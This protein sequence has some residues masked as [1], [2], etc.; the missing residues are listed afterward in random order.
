MTPRTAAMSTSASRSWPRG[1]P[2]EPALIFG[3]E[4]LTYG[5]L[6]E[7]ANALAHRLI[8]HGVKPETTVG[9]LIED[10]ASRII[11]LLAVLK[12]GGAYLPLDP[13]LP[14]TRLA[15]MVEDA[16]ASIVLSERHLLAS[17]PQEAE[18]AVSFDALELE[19]GE[20]ERKN[21]AVRLEGA[22]LAYVVFT[23]GS[24]GRAR[25]V[26]VSHQSLLNAADAWEEAYGL[27]NPPLR[28][29]QAAAFSFDVFT[30][31][32]VRAL[33]TGGVLV[34][35]PR[36]VLL[37][38]GALADLIRR[39]RIGFVELVPAVAEASP[40]TWRPRMPTRSQSRSSR[41]A[42]TP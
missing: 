16:R 29:L 4:C 20:A 19:P 23:S 22:N 10:W 1:S 11:G 17:V 27:A 37:D 40:P 32:W 12:A 42:R 36:D 35:C 28:H 25:G 18:K 30:G 21:P 15:A 7:K 24:T 39:E 26:M 14:G 8:A 5:E 31:D 38:P 33:T 6:N 34:N 13:A 41:W 3:D 9:L 2:D